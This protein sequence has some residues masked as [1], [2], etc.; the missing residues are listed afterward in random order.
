MHLSDEELGERPVANFTHL[1]FDEYYRRMIQT[2]ERET[3]LFALPSP[4]LHTLLGRKGSLERDSYP[5]PRRLH[6]PNACKIEG[7]VNADSRLDIVTPH[8]I[9]RLVLPGFRDHLLI[10]LD[11]ME[12]D[13]DTAPT[14]TTLTRQFA[15]DLLLTAAI[16]AREEPLPYCSQHM[17]L[18]FTLYRFLGEPGDNVYAAATSK[19]MSRLRAMMLDPTRRARVLVRLQSRTTFTKK[20]HVISWDLAQSSLSSYFEDEE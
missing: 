8:A 12:N 10:A 9:N 15:H 17:M 5:G 6:L 14:A 3:P 2:V 19:H 18:L 7:H 4:A 20:S 13:A 16:T 11:S 1:E